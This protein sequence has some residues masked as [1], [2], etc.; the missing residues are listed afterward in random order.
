MHAPSSYDNAIIIKLLQ[1]QKSYVP[2]YIVS[3][4]KVNIQNREF[5]VY[6]STAESSPQQMH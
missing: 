4:L 5:C 3:S 6:S 2:A 1:T